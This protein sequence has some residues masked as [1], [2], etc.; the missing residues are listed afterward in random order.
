M[1]IGPIKSAGGK[2]HREVVIRSRAIPSRTGDPS[3]LQEEKE[4]LQ[5][6]KMGI[7]RRS[8]KPIK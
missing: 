7:R 2:L 8:I 4:I 1:Q 6:G 5:L 3:C